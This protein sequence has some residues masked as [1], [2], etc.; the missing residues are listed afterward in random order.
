MR[1]LK[2]EGETVTLSA[3]LGELTNLRLEGRIVEE[4]AAPV[5][6][7][8]TATTINDVRC[9]WCKTSPGYDC[10]MPCGRIVKRGHVERRAA[11][12]LA[13]DQLILRG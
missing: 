10:R 13:R 2:I 3:S 8:A 6:W 11:F 4:L 12:L 1:V 9:P 5:P 7:V